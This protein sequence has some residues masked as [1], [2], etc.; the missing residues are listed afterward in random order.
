[1]R[2]VETVDESANFGRSR[3]VGVVG[4][5]R[6]RECSLDPMLGLIRGTAGEEQES[7]LL[8]RRFTAKGLGDIRSHGIRRAHQLDAYAPL[9][10]RPP[11]GNERSEV[12]GEGN[13]PPVRDQVLEAR[14]DSWSW[15]NARSLP[16]ATS[17]EQLA[18]S[19]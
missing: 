1:M 16:L 7:Q 10:E 2:A 17:H 5:Q 6:A 18:T 11:V 3:S 9:V 14:H 12:I 13:G 19:N 4:D 8:G 15:S